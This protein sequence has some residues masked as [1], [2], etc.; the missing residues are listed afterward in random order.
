MKYRS[1]INGLRALAVMAVIADHVGIYAARGGFLGVDVFFVISGFL[2]TGIIYPEIEAGHFSSLRFYERRV[3]RIVPALAAMLVVTTALSYRYLLPTEMKGF[4]QSLVAAVF[5]AS[6]IWFFSTAGYFDAL[7]ASKPLLHTWSLAVEEQFYVVFPV[8]LLLVHR[9]FGHRLKPTVAIIFVMSLAASILTDRADPDARFY[10]PWNRAWE[11]MMG[12]LISLRMLPEIRRAALANALSLLGLGLIAGSI[13][14]VNE[15]SAFLGEK[16]II[17]CVGAMMVIAAGQTQV[18][19]AGRMLSLKPVAYIGLI[20]YS[21]YLWHWPIIVFHRMGLGDWMHLP[22]KFDKLLLVLVPIVPAALSYKFVEQ[23]FRGK[24]LPQRLVFRLALASLAVFTITGGG[25]IA[26]QGLAQRFSPA[27]NRMSAF[28]DY[29]ANSYVRQGQCF[30][31]SKDSFADFDPAVC[32]KADPARKT[33]LLYGDSHAAHLWYGLQ[34]A[35]PGIDVM[36]ATAS[37]CSPSRTHPDGASA[38]CTALSD[39]MYGQYLPDHKPDTMLLEA[40]WTE[41]DMAGLPA[42]LDQAKAAAGRVVLFGP[43]VRY[44]A[45]LPR[46]LATGLRNHDPGYANAHR[47]EE[48][49]DLDRAMAKIA[50]EKGVAYIS[51]FDLLCQDGKCLTTLP[52]GTPLLYD[53]GHLTKEGSLAVAKLIRD[54]NELLQ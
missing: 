44:D 14:V 43:M 30:I 53:Y 5:G 15:H 17:P 51:F 29:K 28:L 46:L 21:L 27:V 19:L 41:G 50:E 32:L 20:S 13:L 1:D 12:A 4:G 40:A 9:S 8:I 26:T 10:L 37:G 23:P 54:S 33:Y 16:T 39:F 6:N 52:D 22:V 48:A 11:L 38:A 2:I 3:R 34:T 31:T 36:Q 47:L 35:F 45:A 24:A 25:L 42:L 18:T 49:H 7:A